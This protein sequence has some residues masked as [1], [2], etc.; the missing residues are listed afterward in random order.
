MTIE[1]DRVLAT[2]NGCFTRA[3]ALL[4]GLSPDETR[5]HLAKGTWNTIRRGVY[6]DREVWRD[7]DGQ[8][9]AVLELQAVSLKADGPVVGSH[10]TAAA[11]LGIELW[12]ASDPWVHITRPGASGRREARVW[13]H[14][15]SLPD[16]EIVERSSLL[17]TSP[18]RTGLDLA[19]SGIDHEHA[20][21]AVDSAIRVCGSTYEA[22]AGAARELLSMHLDRADWCGARTAGGAVSCCDP[23]SG[24][25]GES[26][27]RVAFARSG[28]PTPL[29]QVYVYDQW[30][31]LVG[32]T[33]FVFEEHKT[34]VEFDGRTKYGL[35][36]LDPDAV[37]A[38]LWAEKLRGE[39]LER[40]GWQVVRIVWAD[41]YH[42]ARIG[43]RVRDAFD[44]ASRTSSVRG[45]YALEPR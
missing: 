30:G 13:H 36:G 32:I 7:A 21:V 29:T 31:K 42:P 18:L 14:E 16:E 12:E 6:V 22:R 40:L 44:R 11:V 38:R 5:R 9:R 28:L 3:Q 2:Q 25:V 43:A 20:V 33:D 39:S 45:S 34:I 41:L 24:S 4:S 8:Q 10:T 19:R 23:R 1:L 37:A 15:A 35:D 27:A 26:R 17:V